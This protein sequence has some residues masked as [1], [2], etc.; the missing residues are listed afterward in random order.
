MH[1]ASRCRSVQ[2]NAGCGHRMV[3]RFRARHHGNLNVG[4]TCGDDRNVVRGERLPQPYRKSKRQVF[5][6]QFVAELRAY[7]TVAVRRIQH[8]HI[9]RL[10]LRPL[11]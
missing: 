6:K 11:R 1:A 4:I 7:I 9:L 8:D 10:H 3:G 2:R 5:L